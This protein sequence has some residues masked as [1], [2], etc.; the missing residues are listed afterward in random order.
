MENLPSPKPC[1]STAPFARSLPPGL[2]LFTSSGLQEDNSFSPYLFQK[3]NTD[4]AYDIHANTNNACK[5]SV[6]A[7]DSS[8]FPI[9]DKLTNI[10]KI[11]NSTF[12]TGRYAF[13]YN[14]VVCRKRQDL[15]T[16]HC[17]LC[18][19]VTSS[20]SFHSEKMVPKCSARFP[21]G[22]SRQNSYASSSGYSSESCSF[23]SLGFHNCSANNTLG[24]TCFKIS[25][26]NNNNAI[27]NSEVGLN[28]NDDSNC[29]TLRLGGGKYNLNTR[30]GEQTESTHPASCKKINIIT[31]FL[32][33]KNL[34]PWKSKDCVKTNHKSNTN[35]PEHAIP[36]ANDLNGG[37]PSI[38]VDSF[39][40]C[41]EVSG[42]PE[43][44]DSG[45]S[46]RESV[47]IHDTDIILSLSSTQIQEETHPKSLDSVPLDNVYEPEYACRCIC[48]EL[49]KYAESLSSRP[50]IEQK[51]PVTEPDVKTN[52]ET[53]RPTESDSKVGVN[54]TG[55]IKS[56]G[57]ANSFLV[58]TPH[59]I[60]ENR[61]GHLPPK[62][63][64]E[65]SRHRNLYNQMIVASKRKEA[66]EF[67]LK[68][69]LQILA[70]K[71]E[72]K[73][74]Q[75]VKTWN[76]EILNDWENMKNSKKTR[77]LW[78]LGLP[79]S[80]R[81]KIW[82]LALAENQSS[83]IDKDTI[84]SCLSRF[85]PAT[86]HQKCYNNISLDV[87]RTFPHLC[88]FQEGGPYHQTLKDLLVAYSVY[89]PEIGY[90][91]GMSFIGA[92]LLLNMEP[93]FQ[94]F[95]KLD[96]NDMKK[97]FDLYSE[98][99]EVNLPELHDHFAHLNFTPDLYLTDWI[100]TIYSKSL[101]LDVTCKIWDLF[102]RD[103]E[104]F[105]FRTALGILK[106]NEDIL[107]NMDFMQAAEFLTKLPDNMPTE[108]LFK[109]IFKIAI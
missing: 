68:K 31:E 20:A 86:E 85:D 80:I 48:H 8:R 26:A 40:E 5:R 24:K 84:N 37:V 38:Q 87:S 44:S 104:T 51:I 29:C 15:K 105:L 103:G 79:P 74:T 107:I 97:Y 96:Q 82:Y 76:I 1:S 91:Q 6:S 95:Y 65:E 60:L 63:P 64:E 73:L 10:C 50:Q 17:E 13:N 57:K 108:D 11:N 58:T 27:K 7:R 42:R 41:V 92:I 45:I 102:L 83:I 39:S 2:G 18:R 89:N 99:L 52:F 19:P 61:P 66:K 88:I 100:Y 70:L 93:C 78:E 21:G 59:L 12:G 81:G 28:L 67:K 49:S 36:Y 72:E 14:Q 33:T 69:K 101:Q 54:V 109:A 9:V 43:T 94:T 25:G 35:P 56:F 16:L 53:I 90:V 46:S 62:K 34:F 4:T 32:S 30:I 75:L 47:S 23:H 71:S 55:R 77:T 106:L 3:L 22:H 98:F